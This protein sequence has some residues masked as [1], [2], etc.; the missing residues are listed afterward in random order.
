MITL[1]RRNY[2]LKAIEIYEQ[3]DLKDKTA[4]LNYNLGLTSIIREIMSSLSL[5]IRKPLKV[6]L[7]QVI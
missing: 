3:H 6:L 1:N 7:R 4:L 5:I 2:L